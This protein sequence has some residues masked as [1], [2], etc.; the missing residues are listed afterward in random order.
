MRK[1]SGSSEEE[2]KRTIWFPPPAFASALLN[3]FIERARRVTFDFQVGGTLGV[4]GGV[5]HLPRHGHPAV[6]Q[7]ERVFAAVLNDVNVL[8]DHMMC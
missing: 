8:S 2:E 4:S 7:D 6:V 1:L 5:D 3:G